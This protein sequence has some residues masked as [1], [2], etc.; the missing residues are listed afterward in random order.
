MRISDWSS[1]VCSSDLPRDVAAH[2]L[3]HVGVE[4]SIAAEVT[5]QPSASHQVYPLHTIG[6][7]Q[8]SDN[9]GSNHTGSCCV[10]GCS[11]SGIPAYAPSA[12]L[13]FTSERCAPAPV[14]SARAL[15]I[16]PPHRPPRQD[17]KSTRLNSS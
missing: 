6:H 12:L 9:D 16:A 15:G 13:G 5:V 7:H 10:V 4:A 8:H 1:D 2:T 17:R 3:D 14:T 11:A